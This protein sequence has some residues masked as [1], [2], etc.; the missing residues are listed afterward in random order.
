MT[1]RLPVA[2]TFTPTAFIVPPLTVASVSPERTVT[3]T[4]PPLADEAKPPAAP[5]AVV[6]TLTV[7]VAAMAAVPAVAV[8]VPAGNR[9]GGR[10]GDVGSGNRRVGIGGAC[11]GGRRGQRRGHVRRG[12]QA[13]VARGSESSARDLTFAPDVD[14]TMPALISPLNRLALW[15]LTLMVDWAASVMLWPVRLPP[16]TVMLAEPSAVMVP[17]MVTAPL[18]AGRPS[19]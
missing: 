19:G 6:V 17:G 18:L 7:L 13:Q 9:H 8:S 4:V 11:R 10:A 14:E 2:D 12:R 16:L 15:L 3:A 5:L 1:V